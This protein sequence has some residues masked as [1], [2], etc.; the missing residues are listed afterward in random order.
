[1]VDVNILKN[2]SADSEVK[3]SLVQTYVVVLS[4]QLKEAKGAEWS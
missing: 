2:K 1:M 3:K 4:D